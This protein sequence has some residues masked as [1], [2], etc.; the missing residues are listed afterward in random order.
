MVGCR[1]TDRLSEQ[2]IPGL[3][4]SG[5]KILRRPEAHSAS[6]SFCVNTQFQRLG[7]RCLWPFF[8]LVSFLSSLPHAAGDS[9]RGG[10]GGEERDGYLQYRF[11]SLAFHRFST[12]F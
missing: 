4:A 9:Q 3:P 7:G 11:P 12:N 1:P 2:E 10:D 5:Q 8:S 6:R